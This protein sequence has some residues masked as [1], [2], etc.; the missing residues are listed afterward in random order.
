MSNTVQG[1]SGE[2]GTQTSPCAFQVLLPLAIALPPLYIFRALGK[3]AKSSRLQLPQLH[4]DDLDLTISQ[5]P[6]SSSSF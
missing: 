2:S 1:H 5:V 6:A 4:N 3:S